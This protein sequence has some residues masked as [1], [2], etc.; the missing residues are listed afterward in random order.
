MYYYILVGLSF[1]SFFIKN[2]P[3]KDKARHLLANSYIFFILI[4]F[5]S[6]FRYKVGTDF[7]NYQNIF[8]YDSPIEPLF[9]LLIQITKILK[10]NY[11]IF[12][13]I[14]FI[15]S[16]GLK[17]YTFKKLSYPK[18]FFLSIMLFCSF[19]YIAY[20]INAIRQGLAMS[21]TLLA[22]YFAYIKHKTKYYIVCIIATLVHYTAFIFIPLYFLLRFQIRKRNA[23]LICILSFILS[24][25]GIFNIL[26]QC[27]TSLLGNSTISAQILN[28]STSE[29]FDNNLLYSMSTIR[30]IFFFILILISYDKIDAS[31]QIQ[32]I[33]FWGGFISIV[34]YLLF[35]EVGYFSIRLSAYY[36]ITE[37]IWLSY[38]PFI[39]KAKS[40][41]VCTIIFYFFYS[42]LQVHSALSTNNNGLVPIQTIFFQ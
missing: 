11:T 4:F 36:R 26:I 13:A 38:F 29:V 20:D 42:L 34:T 33:I 35:A 40:T 12:V 1:I 22:T 14:I 30:R 18:G 27:A 10:G 23:L 17:L 24:Q 16:F 6:S 19:Y 37:C 25:Y 21:L 39:F 41:K 5:I 8:K 31:K 32:Q 28:Y 15:L 2:I 9:Y 3:I 7:V